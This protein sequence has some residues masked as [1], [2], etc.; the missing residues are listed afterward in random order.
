MKTYNQDNIEPL[1][2]FED[3]LAGFEWG[4]SGVNVSGANGTSIG[5]GLQN[6]L[7][8]VNQGCITENGGKTAAQ[9]TL[10]YSY[11]DYADWYLPSRDE[12][13]QMFNV[14]GNGGNYGNIGGF[15]HH[16]TFEST[17]CHYNYYWSSTQSDLI[18]FAVD[19][20]YEY[21]YVGGFTYAQ[22]MPPSYRRNT[23]YRVR[24]IR[25]F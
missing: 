12:L 2:V 21:S 14:I 17:N 15:H 8:I 5:T 22:N 24:P 16:E 7:A 13:E 11:S 19:G 9:A 10:D 25:S 20:P 1:I 23:A 4:C 6:T 18:F 3:M